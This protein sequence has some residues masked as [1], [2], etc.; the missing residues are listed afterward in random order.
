MHYWHLNP[1]PLE[2]DGAGRD[3]QEPLSSAGWLRAAAAPEAAHRTLQEM[4]AQS[5]MDTPQWDLGLSLEMEKLQR[6]VGFDLE[7][8][9]FFQPERFCGSVTCMSVMSLFAGKHLCPCRAHHP[10]LG[11]RE[12]GAL[13][14]TT[15]FI[16]LNFNS[17]LNLQVPVVPCI[18]W[19]E[20]TVFLNCSYFF[21]S[22]IHKSLQAFLYLRQYFPAPGQILSPPCTS[23]YSQQHMESGWMCSHLGNTLTRHSN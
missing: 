15:A 17:A 14:S 18:T 13:G 21:T 16:H 2:Q 3:A 12:E 1:H 20:S 7:F 10:D 4:M 22:Y 5:D 9:F 8:I 19:G 6:E 11:L 23:R